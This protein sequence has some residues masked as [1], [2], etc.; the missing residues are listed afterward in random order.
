[1]PLQRLEEEVQS[2]G[3]P[4]GDRR[5]GGRPSDQPQR[6]VGD[7]RDGN[8]GLNSI[9]HL[10]QL[11]FEAQFS[12]N[13]RIKLCRNDCQDSIELSPGPSTRGSP[14]PKQNDLKS[15]NR[16]HDSINA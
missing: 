3:D 14:L 4:D 15:M 10:Y 1:M 12:S 2:D 7:Q 8:Q 11:I 5:H 9:D 13:V 16:R 6:E